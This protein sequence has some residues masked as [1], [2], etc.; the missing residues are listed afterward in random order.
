MSYDRPGYRFL[1]SK[2]LVVVVVATN[3]ELERGC[4][5]VLEFL[6]LAVRLRWL[7]LVLELG[8]GN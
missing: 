2:V 4:V 8:T 3:C 5:V 1:A 6:T 7:E